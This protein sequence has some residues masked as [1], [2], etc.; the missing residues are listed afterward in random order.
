MKRNTISPTRA[1]NY[2]EWYQQVVDAAELAENSPVRGCMV[3]KPW[4]HALWENMQRELDDMFKETGHRN[5][6]FPLLIPKSLLEKEAEHVDGFAKECAV[7]THHRLIHAADGSLIPDPAAELEEPLIIRPTSETIVGVMFAKWI[8]SYRDLP[9]LINQW[10]NVVRWEMRTRLFLRTSEFL[11]QEGHTAHETES[12]AREEATRMLDI[13]TRFVED[14]LAIPVIRGVNS[15]SERFPGAI[16]TYAIEAMMG[17]C[18]ALQAGT[19]HFLGQNFAKAAGIEFQGRERGSR[20]F[21]WTTSW[22][23]S[24]RLIGA[25]IMV[26]G[27]DDG[28]VLPPRIAPAQVVILPVHRSEDARVLVDEYVDVV[29]SRLRSMRFADRKIRV[30]IDRRELRGGQKQWEWIKKGVPI[31]LEIGLRDKESASVTL[32]RRDR[33]SSG[34][35][36]VSFADLPETVMS[37]FDEI[38][39]GCFERARQLFG[40]YKDNE[41]GQIFPRDSWRRMRRDCNI[42]FVRH[43]RTGGRSR[44][45]AQPRQRI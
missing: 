24:T 26:H 17:D 5:A 7:V 44:L 33:E 14:Y 16:D 10:A 13:Y 28:I 37:L 2:A 32:S 41:H 29:A 40:R 30:E 22:G 43:Q 39:H 19:S 35:M 42:A 6:Y 25:L 23:A 3:I 20:Q 11:W 15:D 34:K 18:K 38:Q 27:D 4:G 36:S 21:A 31:R 45:P 9:L 12:E 1:E 8:Q